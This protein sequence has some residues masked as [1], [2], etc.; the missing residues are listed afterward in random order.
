MKKVGWREI[1]LTLY[2][3]PGVLVVL[4]WRYLDPYEPRARGLWVF[5]WIAL[6]M[7][8]TLIADRVVRSR[9]PRGGERTGHSGTDALKGASGISRGR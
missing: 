8:P 6:L 3:V 7:A 9:R 2:L 4:S 1:L 5:F